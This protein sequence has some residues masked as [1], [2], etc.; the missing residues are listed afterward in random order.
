MRNNIKKVL[1]L[2]LALVMLIA[3][4]AAITQAT[5]R[6]LRRT[7]KTHRVPMILP[8]TAQ[9]LHPRAHLVPTERLTPP[10]IPTRP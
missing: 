6:I 1:A 2:M 5:L 9:R 8:R 7:P 3:C 4:T 10:R